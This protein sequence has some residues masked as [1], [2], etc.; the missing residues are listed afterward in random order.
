MRNAASFLC[1]FSS[2]AA[3]VGEPT[4]PLGPQELSSDLSVIVDQLR[5][6]LANAPIDGPQRLVAD[7][8]ML[9]RLNRLLRDCEAQTRLERRSNESFGQSPFDSLFGR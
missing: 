1:L 4:A 5:R 2:C 3:C 8:A 6:S 9:A 7:S